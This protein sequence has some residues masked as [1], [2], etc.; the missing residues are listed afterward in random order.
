MIYAG[1]AERIPVVDATAMITAIHQEHDY[2]H[3]PG[4][5]PHYRLPESRE[6]VE[7]A[8]GREMI[9]RLTDADWRITPAGLGK[10]SWREFGLARWIETKLISSFGPGW[11]SRIVRMVFH[12]LDTMGYFLT[13]LRE[14]LHRLMPSVFR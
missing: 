1:R 7:L 12:P 10:K 2:S 9:F 8:G 6:N 11:R 13:R 14:P 5:E 3:L 4:G